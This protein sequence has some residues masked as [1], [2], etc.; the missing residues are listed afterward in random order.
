MTDVTIIPMT[1]DHVPAA[2]EIERTVFPDPWTAD[3]FFEVIGITEKCWVAVKGERTIGYLL[4][5]WVSVEI[6]LLNV[7][8]TPDCQRTG[9]GAALLNFLLCLGERH[10]MRDVYL[11]VRLSNHAAQSLY[12][13]C[14]FTKLAVRKRYYRDGEDALVMHR[15]LTDFHLPADDELAAGDTSE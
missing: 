3:S 5:Q 2:A 12:L 11:E 13:G 10:G 1:L 7:A 8:V 4:T 6:H 9:I 14:G 15:A